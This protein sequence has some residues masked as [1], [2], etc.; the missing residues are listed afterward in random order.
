MS[1][2]SAGDSNSNFNIDSSSGL[3]TTSATALFLHQWC[4]RYPS[5]TSSMTYISAGDSNSNFN[6]DSSSGLITTS[7]TALF[8]HQ[9]CFCYPSPTSSMPYISAGDSNSNFNI[10][11]SSGLIT[12]S[13]TA[14][15]FSTNGASVTLVLL[16]LCH[17]FQLVTAIVTLILTVALD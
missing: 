7:A 4:F 6:I 1:Y 3:I 13:A 10:D 9:W 5:P 14:L 15:S 11:S 17:I 8:L 2:I 12:T 16:R